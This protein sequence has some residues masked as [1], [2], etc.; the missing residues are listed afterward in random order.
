MI[1]RGNLHR[2]RGNDRV[3]LLQGDVLLFLRRLAEA[4]PYF[5][6]VFRIQVVTKAF[7]RTDDRFHR[8]VRAQK[9]VAVLCVSFL[10]R[11]GLLPTRRMADHVHLS[12]DPADL[13]GTDG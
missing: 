7:R 13:L 5:L 9:D 3:Q 4:L 6:L 1:G 8:I 10:L 2:F 11:R 12:G